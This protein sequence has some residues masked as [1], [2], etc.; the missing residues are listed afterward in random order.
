MIELKDSIEEITFSFLDIYKNVRK[1][2]KDINPKVLKDEDYILL[3]KRF[4][5]LSNK[6]GIKLKTCFEDEVLKFGFLKGECISK[7]LAFRLTGKSFKKWKERDC[8]CR[9]IVDIGQYNTCNH[10]CKYCYANYDEESIKKNIFM[11]DPNS[12]LLIGLLKETDIIKVRRK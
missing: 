5:E 10:R 12:S 2:Y 11:R 3:S 4:K 1:N 9:E 8:G 7:E 6:Y